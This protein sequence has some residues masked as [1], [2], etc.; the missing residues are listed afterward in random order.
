MRHWVLRRDLLN[1]SPLSTPRATTLLTRRQVLPCGNAF[2]EQAGE[3]VQ[4]TG[5]A[6]QWLPLSSLS[7]SPYSM[8]SPTLW[9]RLRRTGSSLRDATCGSRSAST[10]TQSH[11][12]RS[13]LRVYMGETPKTALSH[14]LRVYA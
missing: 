11:S 2:S 14:G 13:R 1:D 10:R 12:T 9:E 7:S 5:S 3:P 6:T 4:R 8:R